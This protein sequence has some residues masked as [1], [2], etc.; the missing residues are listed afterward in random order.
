MENELPRGP[1][2]KVEAWAVPPE[3]T[4][5]LLYRYVAFAGMEANGANA[6]TALANPLL[7]V[8]MIA[9]CADEITKAWLHDAADAVA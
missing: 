2:S 6:N 7:K 8:S 3:A 5:M 1:L 9:L 4:P